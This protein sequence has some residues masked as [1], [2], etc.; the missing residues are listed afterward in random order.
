MSKRD[1]NTKRFVLGEKANPA[2]TVDTSTQPAGSAFRGLDPFTAALVSRAPRV[3]AAQQIFIPAVA[4]A[5]AK[6][7]T[8]IPVNP[9]KTENKP[10]PL[11]VSGIGAALGLGLAVFLGKGLNRG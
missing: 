2:A 11:L 6:I 8:P 3:E 9:C 1:P 10:N 4:P 7:E 5:P